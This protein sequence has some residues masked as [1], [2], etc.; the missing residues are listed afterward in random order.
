LAQAHAILDSW[1]RDYNGLRPLANWTPEQFRAQHNAVAAMTSNGRWMKEGAHYST[2]GRASRSRT[3]IRQ[4][5]GV[6]GR[7]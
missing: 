6:W 5:A 7:P 1:R 2:S 3:R 4:S